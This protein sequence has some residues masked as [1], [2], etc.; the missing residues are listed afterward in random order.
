M[1]LNFPSIGGAPAEETVYY[2]GG[3]EPLAADLNKT[4]AIL[5]GPNNYSWTFQPGVFAP[6]DWQTYRK[7][8]TGDITLARGTGV[9]F[10][11]VW[12]NIDLKIDGSYGNFVHIQ[13]IEESASSVVLTVNESGNYLWSPGFR[14]TP[15]VGQRILFSGFGNAA[16]NGVKTVNGIVTVAE[17]SVVETLVTEGQADVRTMTTQETFIVS[18]SVK[19]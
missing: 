13:K 8:G 11:S 7:S 2:I 12:G 5:N 19:T 15:V 3:G 4:I 18:G 17:I 1:G 16:N 14:F 9:T 10:L 6:D